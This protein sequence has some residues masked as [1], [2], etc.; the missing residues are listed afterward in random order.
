M[1]KSFRIAFVT[2]GQTPRID[3]VPEMM[4]DI[5][6]GLNGVEVTCQEFGVLDGL[7]D[8]ELNALHAQE[9]EHSF[10]TRLKSGVEIVTSKKL[11]EERLNLILQTIDNQGFNLIVLLCTGT[12]IVPLKKTLVVE[13]QRI[14]DATVAALTDD[15]ALGVIL[16]LERQINDFHERHVFSGKTKLVAASPYAGGDIEKKAAELSDCS[17]IIMHCM[18]YSGAM[19]ERARSS[20]KAPVLLSRRIVS[21]TIRQMI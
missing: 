9:G 16:P 11:T 12:H 15:G 3:I 10:A 19:L 2:I 14:V 7:N 20:C 1:V 17:L 13:A 18:G 6:A 4:A 5:T 8:A 21:S